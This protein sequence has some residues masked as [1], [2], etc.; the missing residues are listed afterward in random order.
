M[1]SFVHFFNFFLFS[2]PFLH[3]I[4]QFVLAVAAIERDC[5]HVNTYIVNG[6]VVQSQTMCQLAHFD[7]Y[8][9][10]FLLPLCFWDW[11]EDLFYGYQIRRIHDAIVRTVVDVSAFVLFLLA[12]FLVLTWSLGHD[13][14]N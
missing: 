1:A 7:L 9:I 13:F 12:C 2:A 10:F 5:G 11:D 4:H 14:L 8:Y 3:I 6:V